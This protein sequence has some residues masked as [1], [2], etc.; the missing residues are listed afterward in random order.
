VPVVITSASVSLDEQ[1][2]ARRRKYLIMMGIR[3]V[4]II[5]AVSVVSFS[6]WLAL[7]FMVGGAVL[8]W[9]AVLIANDRPPQRSTAF[10][11]Y[12]GTSKKAVGAADPAT[13]TGTNAEVPPSGEPGGVKAVYVLEA[14]PNPRERD[15]DVRGAHR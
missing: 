14:A 7:A 5:A 9:C 15:D 4:C 6:L 8:P 1:H 10:V 12:R 11:R 3:V 13:V 2:D